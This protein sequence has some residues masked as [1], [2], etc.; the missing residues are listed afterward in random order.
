MKNCNQVCTTIGNI[1]INK[2]NKYALNFSEGMSSGN[3]IS[4]N[5]NGDKI[6]FKKAGTYKFDLNGTAV[7]KNEVKLEIIFHSNLFT[8]DMRSFTH[9]PLHKTG[10]NFTFSVSTCFPICKGQIV[11][12][13]LIPDVYEDIILLDRTRLTIQLL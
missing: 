4:I 1:M 6:H 5:K 2:D 8:K 7:P 13:H 10:D 12:I 11:S 3:K 9:I